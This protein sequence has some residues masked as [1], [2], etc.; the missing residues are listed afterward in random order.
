M[1]AY[2]WLFVDVGGKIDK[3]NELTMSN[4]THAVILAGDI[5]HIP[6]W[7][8]FCSQLNLKVIAIICSDYH[9]VADHIESK[10]PI[11]AGSIHYLERGEDV[12]ERSMLQ[13][14]S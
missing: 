9:G 3:R 12:S 14:L 2:L 4:A 1:Q 10:A 5:N 6:G 13:E 8:K 11:L 7:K